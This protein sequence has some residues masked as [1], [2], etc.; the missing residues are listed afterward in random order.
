ME[1]FGNENIGMNEWN[2]K[3]FERVSLIE[4]VDTLY[5]YFIDVQ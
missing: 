2:R 5:L 1:N 3:W 4:S